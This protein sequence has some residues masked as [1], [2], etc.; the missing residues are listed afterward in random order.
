MIFELIAIK[1]KTNLVNFGGI[2]KNDTF[3]SLQKDP[4]E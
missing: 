2:F 1:I 3:T 4:K